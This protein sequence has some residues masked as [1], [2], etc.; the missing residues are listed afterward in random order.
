MIGVYPRRRVTRRLL[1]GSAAMLALSL[2]LPVAHAA[3][4]TVAGGE[5]RSLGLLTTGEAIL[6]GAGTSGTLNVAPGSTLTLNTSDAS[7]A[8]RLELGNGGSGVLNLTGGTIRFNIAASSA[9]A[10]TAIGRLWVGGGI[11]NSAGGTGAVNMTSGLLDY[12]ELDPN[13]L[14][15]GGLAIGRGTGVTGAFN[16]SGGTVR[17]ASTGAIDIGTQGGTG[18][19]LLGGNAVLDM[20][21]GGGTIYVGSRTGAGGVTSTGSLRISDA[22]SVTLTTGAN[23]GGQLYVGDARS[24]GS[25]V[26]D[27]AG[28]VVTLGLANPILFG[29]N[30]NNAGG[31]GGGGTG[32]YALS[33]GTLNVL[34][35]GGSQQLSFGAAAGGRGEFLLSGGTANIATNLSIGAVAGSTGLLRQTGGTLSLTGTSRLYVG[36]GTG[37]YELLGGRLQL[38]GTSALY[39]GGSLTFGTATLGV[40]GSNLTI[41]DAATLTAGSLFTIDTQGFNASLSGVLSGSGGLAKAGSGTLT[42]SAA[43]TYSGPT[44]IGAGTLALSGAGSIAASAGLANNGTFD[45]SATTA[46]TSIATLSGN[47]RVDVGLRVLA[48]G[49]NNGSSAFSGTIVNGGVNWDP[50]YG[51]FAKVGTGTLTLDGATISGGEAHVRGGSIAV[52]SGATRVDYLAIGTGRTSGVSNVGGLGVSGGALTVGTTLQVGDFGGIGSVTQTGGTVVVDQLCGTSS[53][54]ASINVGNQGGTGTYSISG[55]TLSLLRASLALG[56]N[57]ATNPAGSGTLNLSG[58][59]LVDLTDGRFNIGNWVSV[60]GNTPRSSG[61]VNQTGGTLRIRGGG[62]LYLSGS[63]NGVYDLLGGALE[64][65]GSSLRANYGNGSGTYALNL[66]GGTVRAFGSALTAPVNANLLAGTQSTIDS[67]G[68]GMTWSGILSGS[69]SLAK[70]GAGTLTLSA[71]NSYSGATTI[72]SGTLAL[73]GT[74]SIAASSAL[75]NNGIFDISATT[76]GASIASLAGSG[77]VDTGLRLLQVGSGN[78]DSAF[79]GTIVNG[80]LGWLPSYGRFQKLGTG[81]LTL[82]GATITGGES[83][84]TGGA[85]AQTSGSTAINYLAVGS[86]TTSGVANVGAL[87]VSGGS[88]T[89]GTGLQVGDFGGSGTVNQTGGAIVVRPDCGDAARCALFNIGNQGGTGVYNISGGSLTLDSGSFGLGRNTSNN[90][91][92]RGTLNLSGTG[93]VDLTAGFFTIGNWIVVNGTTQRGSGVVNQTGGTFR[94]GPAT[95]LYL[96]GSGNGV[97]NLLGGALEIGG[98]SLNANYNNNGGSYQ[99]NLGGGTVR[100]SGSA[101]TA[102][103]NATLLDGTQSS[104]DSNGL[105]LTWSGVL[106]GTGGLA[107]T[108]AGTVSLTGTNSYTGGT[109]IATGTLQIG[110]GG[111]AGSIVGDVVNNA[112]LAFNRSDAQSFGGSISGSGSLT[113]AGA[114]TLTLTGTNSY[115]GATTIA[116]GTLALAGGGRIVGSIVNDA[117]FDISATTGADVVVGGLSG[118]GVVTIGARTLGLAA[119]GGSFAGS[120]AGT[121][122]L[123]LA[124]GTQIL[125]GTSTYSGGTTIAGGTLQIGNGG[126]TGS[127]VGDVVDHGTLAFDRADAV[128]FG[129]LISGSGALLKSGVGTLTLT[130]A[131]S[132]SGTTTIASGTLALAG[133]GRVVSNVAANGIF[134]LSATSGADVAIGALSGSGSVTL[135]AR[136]LALTGNGANF[137]GIIAGSGGLR[138][139]GGSQ[140]LTGASSFT[141]GTTIAAGTLRLGAGGSGGSLVGPVRIDGELIVDRSDDVSLDGVLTGDGALTKVG[142]NRLTLTAANSF[143]GTTTIAA[144]TLAV[145]GAGRLAGNVVDN[146]ALLFDSPDSFGFGGAITGSGTLTKAGSGTLTLTGA[147]THVGG[148]TIAAGRLALAGAGRITGILVNDGVFDI[149][150]AGG[151][152]AISSMTGTGAVALGSRTLTLEAAS[153]SFAGTMAG[154]GGLAVAGG[155]QIL[156]GASN[157]T[158]GTFVATGATLQLGAGG[159][160][161]GIVG[162]AVVDGTLAFNRS[163]AV[164]FGGTIS[165]SGALV[166]SGTGALTLGGANSYTGGTLVRSGTLALANDHAAGTGRITLESG[167][168][169]SYASGLTVANELRING[170]ANLVVAS[171]TATQSGALSGSGR[172]VL[173]GA[174]RLL[175]TGDNSGFGGGISLSDLTLDLDSSSAL[176]SGAVDLTGSASFRY[177]A[178]VVIA[179][180]I[181]LGSGFTLAA[182]VD[183]G[184]SAT[185][186]G[187]ITGGGTLAKTGG[188]TL[189]LA[190]ANGFT[191]GT[192]LASGTIE[193]VA[194]TAFGTGRVDVAEGGALTLGGG[195]TLANR[196]ELS[197]DAGIGVGA[198]LRAT[199]GGIIADGSRPG[200]IVKTGAGTLTLTAANSFGGGIDI[201]G[202]TVEATRD[203]ALGSGRVDLDAGTTLGL[204]SGVT[205]AN[206]IDLSGVATIGVAAGEVN[207]TTAIEDGERTG[208]LIK[209]GAGQLTLT[210]A[211]RYGGGTTIEAGTLRLGTGG[212]LPG[213]VANAGLLAFGHGERLIFG[214]AISGAGAVAQHGPGTTILTA[215]SSYAGGTTISA[216]TLQLGAGGTSGSIAGDIVNNAALIVDRSDAVTV[217]GR[218]SGA[219]SVVKAGGGT[220]TLTGD[221]S[222]AGGTVI[223]AGTLRVGDG[224]E[225][226]SL[227]GKVDNAGTL[228]FDRADAVAFDGAMSGAGALVKAGAGTLTLAAASSFTGGTTVQAGTLLLANDRAAGLGRILLEGGSTLGYADGITVAN[229]LLITGEARLD[230]AVGTATQAGAITGTGRYLLTGNGRLLITGDNSSFTGPVTISGVNLDLASSSALGSG[231]VELAGDATLSYGAGLEI[232]NDVSLSDGATLGAVVNEGA[233]AIQSGAITGNG[234]VAKTGTGTMVLTGNNDFTGGTTITAGVLQVGNGGSSGSLSGSVANNGT[235]AFNRADTLVFTGTISGSGGIVQSSPGTLVLTGQNS[236]SGGTAITGG[237]LALAGE[238]RISGTVVNNGVFDIAAATGGPV[239]ISGLAGQGTVSLGSQTLALGGDNASFAGTITGSGAVMLTGGSQV[240]TGT[241]THSGGTTISAGTLTASAAALGTGP[242]VGNGALVIEQGAD[243]KLSNPL[244]GTGTLVKSGN[245]RLDLTGVSDFSGTTVV[246]GGRLAVNGMLPNSVVSADPGTILSGSGTVGGVALAPGAALAPGNSIGTLTVAGNVVQAA[247]SIYDVEV[248]PATDRSDR[249]VAEGSATIAPGAVL[250]VIRETPVAYTPGR[251]YTVLTAAGGI[252]GTYSVTGDTAISAFY[253]V[254]ARYA[255]QAVTLEAAQVRAFA[256]AAAGSNQLAVATALDSVAAG[257]QVHDVLGMYGDAALATA[258]FD[259]L[260]GEIDASLRTALTETSRFSREA[261]VDAIRSAAC[262]SEAGCVSGGRAIWGRVFGSSGDVG[263]TAATAALDFST[264]GIVAGFDLGA[265][266]RGRA[267]VYAA[268]GRARF[269]VDARSSTGESE[270]RELGVYGGGSWG[271]V[272]V[273]IGA[274]YSWHDID[275]TRVVAVTGFADRLTRAAKARSLQAFGELGYRIGSATAGVEPFAA[276]AYVDLDTRKSTEA[277]G[278]AALEGFGGSTRSTLSLLGLRADWR[279]TGPASAVG[280][281]ASL[282]WRRAYGELVP[283]SLLALGGGDRFTVEGAPLARDAAVLEAGVHTL[284]TPTLSWNVDYAGQLGRGLGDHGLRG[285]LSWRF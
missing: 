199:I 56:R 15:F 240:L 149:A 88:L 265:G 239:A 40:Q 41:A 26:Q 272:G 207:I 243:A 221:N 234:A 58:T 251:R 152:V 263:A 160:S 45:I 20:G 244:S 275:T 237:T 60:G 232:V 228:I 50:S 145:S 10:A 146:G 22:A 51:V 103:V 19:Y 104:L 241:N 93:L 118:A 25:I 106:S 138:L 143:A 150:G 84:V 217:G 270:N 208:G 202:G 33:A 169:L 197:G 109:T 32:S 70:T 277:G 185:Q 78:S 82:D 200:G 30:V 262:A 193:A 168:T 190:G 53:H 171:G 266:E 124:S 203:G 44:Q 142:S 167:T 24:T 278:A 55:G 159:T 284:I 222:Y 66:G 133:A 276:L 43:E 28:S 95:N 268:A 100:S 242:I 97:Y 128:T 236:F 105:G 144:G 18:S 42:L 62:I 184:R 59:G 229:D 2:P 98:S 274:G 235:L 189:V 7:T 238:G 258:A 73:T 46:G 96:S 90:P 35:V 113:K 29:G 49:T 172:Y 267:G 99:L 166:K 260:S 131:N 115:T 63:G 282:A 206:A 11:G 74:G 101:L 34:N 3:D 183:A 52:T 283:T 195:V 156:T 261:V 227:A 194:N 173:G 186:A 121:G 64:I 72:A 211:N 4:V 134:D 230:V 31:A 77:R 68:L 114:S 174:G 259:Q 94:I 21:S 163:D 280:L 108:G 148:T 65:G 175:L 129:Q 212:R 140:I 196:I 248:D 233:A 139:A 204:G 213:D 111:T 37:S 231:E 281:A 61:L 136:T 205:V 180:T 87:N 157:Y 91:A 249:I 54:C 170:L 9:P 126:T 5:T 269:S 81:T 279:G 247:G 92:S 198:G 220:L 67:N 75:T 154:S 13:T 80:G 226:G 250:N 69:G 135:G 161:G 76:L 89:F 14:N 132:F 255:P 47:G 27:G 36:A 16:Q 178:G 214:G 23:T 225:R 102:S 256:T 123:R 117:T 8:A 116:A 127:L 179:N 137:A 155:A 130:G 107:K 158:G 39:G 182:A 210:A 209:A 48:V 153:G 12:V 177:G 285:T 6:V 85:I 273:R 83:Y 187:A 215:N 245:A 188:G 223:S 112:S 246:T 79:A 216:G 219:G 181:T 120:I 151:G 147:A 201:D 257:Q 224:G 122:G 71:A 191:G 86:G 252:T 176:G 164:L 192:L 1:L 17:F 110:T 119:S 57:T 254:T 125:T 218:I 264:R 162:A 271:G 165:G 141:G 253:A 38:G